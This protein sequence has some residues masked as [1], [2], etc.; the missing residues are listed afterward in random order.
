VRQGFAAAYLLAG[1][2]LLVRERAHLPPLWEA[3][4]GE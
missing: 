4:R 3:L 1:L 2:V